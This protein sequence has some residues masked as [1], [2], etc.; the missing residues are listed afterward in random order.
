[1]KKLLV[2]SIFL[3][4]IFTILTSMA[5]S[6]EKVKVNPNDFVTYK[7]PQGLFEIKIPKDLKLMEEHKEGVVYGD[8][9]KEILIAAGVRLFN[10]PNDVKVDMPYIKE[11]MEK[12]IE[13]MKKAQNGTLVEGPKNY[14][15]GMFFLTKMSRPP[16]PSPDK[17]VKKDASYYT[18]IFVKPKNEKS[19]AVIIYLPEKDYAT[20]KPTLEFIVDSLK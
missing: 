13:Y 10:E 6:E 15:D 9:E 18:F 14:K 5:F 16:F 20:F 4:L 3:I 7:S 1:M 17:E 8:K 12:A 11:Q 19:C 2:L